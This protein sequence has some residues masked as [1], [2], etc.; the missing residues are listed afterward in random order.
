[1][2]EPLLDVVEVEV[3]AAVGSSS[4]GEFFWLPPQESSHV[5]ALSG[6]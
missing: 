2:E 6:T 1:M 5:P 4:A 3:L